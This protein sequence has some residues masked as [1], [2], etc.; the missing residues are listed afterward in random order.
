M[1]S[2]QDNIDGEASFR[3]VPRITVQ[4]CI[5]VLKKANDHIRTCSISGAKSEPPEL[6]K[7]IALQLRLDTEQWPVIVETSSEVDQ[8]FLSTFK[9]AET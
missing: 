3:I 2:S 8:E 1:F 5:Q 6:G 9:D 7:A 4:A